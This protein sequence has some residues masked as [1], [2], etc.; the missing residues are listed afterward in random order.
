MTL[1]LKISLIA[2]LVA[3][4]MIALFQGY[5]PRLVTFA[6]LPIPNTSPGDPSPEAIAKLLGHE[7][8]KGMEEMRN[9]L[10]PSIHWFIA[11]ILVD[12]ISLIA[13]ICCFPVQV[14]PY[15]KQSEQSGGGNSAALR[16]SP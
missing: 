14:A 2:A 5:S 15:R 9:F 4:N 10:A 1:R 8:H 12:S 3:F 7:R 13:L 11:A 6:E 16:A